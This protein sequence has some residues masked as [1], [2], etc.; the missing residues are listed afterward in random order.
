MLDPI[1]CRD[2]PEA[3]PSTAGTRPAGGAI[4]LKTGAERDG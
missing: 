3:T 1:D 2:L 4:A